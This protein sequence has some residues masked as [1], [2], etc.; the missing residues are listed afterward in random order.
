MYIERINKNNNNNIVENN[1]ESSSRKILCLW[2]KF[3]MKLDSHNFN[4]ELRENFDWIDE[5]W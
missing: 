1:L 5:F 4:I 3:D 2:N